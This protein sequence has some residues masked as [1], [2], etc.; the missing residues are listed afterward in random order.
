MRKRLRGS[1]KRTFPVFQ[2]ETSTMFNQL[3]QGQVSRRLRLSFVQLRSDPPSL[4]LGGYGGRFGRAEFQLEVFNC[5]QVLRR[6]EL[7]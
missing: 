4:C 3:S 5:G 7:L 1:A 6:V 2:A